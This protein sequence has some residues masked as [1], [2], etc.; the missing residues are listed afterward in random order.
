MKKEEL[1]RKLTAELERKY[2]GKFMG[3]ID[4][5]EIRFDVQSF[6]ARY[7]LFAK[8]LVVRFEGALIDVDADD[9]IPVDQ[10]S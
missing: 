1:S 6:L 3:D 5:A 7:G 4:E 9:Y 8:H 2:K 10:V